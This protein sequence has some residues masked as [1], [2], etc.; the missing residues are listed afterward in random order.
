MNHCATPG[1]TGFRQLTVSKLPALI[2]K[3][4][5]QKHSAGN[6]AHGPRMHS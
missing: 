3:R 4:G 1:K 6:G 2:R 5:W